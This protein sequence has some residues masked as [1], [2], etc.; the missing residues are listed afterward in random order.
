M[1]A[2]AGDTSSVPG[3][4]RFYMLWS[5]EVHEPK[6][7]SP[8]AAT[9]EAMHL[10]PVLCNKSCRNEKPVHRKGVLVPLASTRESPSRAMKTQCNQ[11]PK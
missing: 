11:K 3:A 2:N 6:L 9:T 1:P 8:R 5:K 7:L 10:K 4:G